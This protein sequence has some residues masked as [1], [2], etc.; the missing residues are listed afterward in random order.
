M[1]FPTTLMI[2]CILV[3]LLEFYAQR[4]S[5]TGS[6]SSFEFFFLEVSTGLSGLL[7][8]QNHSTPRKDNQ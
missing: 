6:L 4:S 3:V 8:L 1:S 5:S 2:P 7:K